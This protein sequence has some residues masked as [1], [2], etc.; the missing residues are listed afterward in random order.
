MLR[1]QTKRKPVETFSP[2]EFQTFLGVVRPEWLTGKAIIAAVI[3]EAKLSGK[4][5]N[6]FRRPRSPRENSG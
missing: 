3:M 5:K 6:E 2:K 4:R 1:D